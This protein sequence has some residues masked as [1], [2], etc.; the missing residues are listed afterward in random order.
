MYTIIPAMSLNKLQQNSNSNKPWGKG[1]SDTPCSNIIFPDI[2]SLNKNLMK[3]HKR[4]A[5]TQEKK[6]FIVP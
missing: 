6:Q 5:P 3:N 4:L 2:S 1:E